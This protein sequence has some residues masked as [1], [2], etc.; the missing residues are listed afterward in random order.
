MS[1]WETLSYKEGQNPPEYITRF[2]S[3][4]D[5][6]ETNNICVG[7][8]GTCFDGDW[9]WLSHDV[10]EAY[11]VTVSDTS[12]NGT[13]NCIFTDMK[14]AVHRHNE[15]LWTADIEYGPSYT[16]DTDVLAILPDWVHV[17]GN[18]GWMDE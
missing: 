7:S 4:D 12:D 1:R 6:P 8:K 17:G 10:G 9:C 18:W 11:L 16:W 15:S 13:V 5:S 2:V 3:G 14:Y